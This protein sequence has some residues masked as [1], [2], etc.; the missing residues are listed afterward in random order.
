MVVA[1]ITS[2]ISSASHAQDF[3]ATMTAGSLEGL[4]LDTNPEFIQN[5]DMLTQGA[6]T[7]DIEKIIREIRKQIETLVTDIKRETDRIAEDK[8]R[9]ELQLKNLQAALDSAIALSQGMKPP[10]DPNTEPSV[11]RKRFE[12]ALKMEELAKLQTP[13][14]SMKAKKKE[15]GELLYLAEKC[16]ADARAR[17]Q[18]PQ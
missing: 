9:L 3:L 13:L 6:C 15:Y 8:N 11:Q 5:L 14:E 4:S 12:I 16:V 17:P 7:D 2:S 18:K 1:L 10:R